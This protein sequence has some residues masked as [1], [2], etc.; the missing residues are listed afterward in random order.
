MHRLWSLYL[1]GNQIADLM[2]IGSLKLLSELDLKRNKIKEVSPL[3]GLSSLQYLSMEGN[4]VSDLTPLVVMA[5]KDA[6]GEKRFAPFWTVYLSPNQ[7][8]AAQVTE[9]KKYVH[10][11]EVAAAKPTE[12]TRHAKASG[13]PSP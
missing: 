9:L 10:T 6:E 4:P 12:T 13:K 2:P 1:D 5:K 11:V 3:D 7:G 8:K